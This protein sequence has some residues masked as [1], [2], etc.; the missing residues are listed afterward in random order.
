MRIFSRYAISRFLI[1]AIF[2]A[3]FFVSIGRL[4]TILTRAKGPS[5]FAERMSYLPSSEKIESLFLGYTSV[6]ADYLWIRTMLY[7]G[8]HSM[9]DKDYP[10]LVTMVDMVTKLN[11]RFYPA[12]EFAAFMIPDFCHDPDAARV[13]LDRGI[14]A[15]GAANWKLPY[16]LGWLYYRE[17]HD[18]VRAASYLQLASQD[19]KVAPYVVGLTARFLR[20]AGLHDQSRR[21]LLSMYE[22]AENPRVREH[23]RQKLASDSLAR[24]SRS[25]EI[26]NPKSE[27]LNK[28]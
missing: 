22:T 9:T 20:D 23:I 8:S 16:Y 13:I 28:F 24:P 1:H 10:W 27:I 15:F 5:W 25:Q 19:P 3:A 18:K 26:L 7:F 21:F 17:Y 4:Q 14:S 2:V 12:Y 11:P 6:Y